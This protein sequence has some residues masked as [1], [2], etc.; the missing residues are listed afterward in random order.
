MLVVRRDRLPTHHDPVHGEF[1]NPRAD[2]GAPG[3]FVRYLHR[4]TVRIHEAP[5]PGSS[6]KDMSADYEEA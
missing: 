2:Q 3:S 1:A 5:C 6:R 4:V